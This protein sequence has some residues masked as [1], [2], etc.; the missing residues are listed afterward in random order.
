MLRQALHGP[1]EE[2]LAKRARVLGAGLLLAM[3][4]VP[5]AIVLGGVDVWFV[6]VIAI[7]LA[8]GST[9]IALLGVGAGFAVGGSWRH[10][11][12]ALGPILMGLPLW[13]FDPGGAGLVALGYSAALLPAFLVARLAVLR[14][15]APL[16][17]PPAQPAPAARGERVPWGRAVLAGLVVVGGCAATYSVT[18]SVHASVLWTI[19]AAHVVAFA[20]GWHRTARD[21]PSD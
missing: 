19:A 9:A 14:A 10:V 8:A 11:A 13:A 3:L 17:A 1:V 15:G 12:G 16:P 20:G 6:T 2:R 5:T 18:S 7:D 21:A 4:V